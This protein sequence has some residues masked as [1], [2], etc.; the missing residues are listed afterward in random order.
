MNSISPFSW[1]IAIMCYNEADTLGPLVARVIAVVCDYSNDFEI[2]IVDDGS[3]DGSSEL[4]DQLAA[5]DDRIRV[6][7]HNPNRGIGEVMYSA[8]TSATKDWISVVPADM[9]FDPEEF[10]VGIEHTQMGKAVCYYP[11]NMPPL[12]RRFF[13]LGQ[14]LLN[15]VLFGLWLK[16]VG[17][18]KILPREAIVPETLISR[19][20]TIETEVIYRLKRRHTPLVWL[21]STN[22]VR[23]DREQGGM[24]L[25]AFIHQA[26][27]SVWDT[28]R[29]RWY[30]R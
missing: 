15:F 2:I 19:S 7:H 16:R 17:W 23:N 5:G 10:R 4:A 11:T 26:I 28:V 3:R 29:L 13:S 1:S 22:T 9:E 14:R 6:I 20:P 8:Y 25:K 21:P 24:D 18:V 12:R 27:R 30:L